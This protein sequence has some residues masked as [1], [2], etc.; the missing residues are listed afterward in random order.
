[1]CSHSL[2]VVTDFS[3]IDMPLFAL[4]A[5]HLPRN[6]VQLSACDVD[7]KALA[8]CRRNHFSHAHY[9]DVTRRPLF[10]PH[11]HLYVAGPPCQ[12]W[13]SFGLRKGAEDKRSNHR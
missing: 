4:R 11:V 7:D 13:S 9:S 10:I 5:L 3:G 12:P 6:L 2:H 8:F 1:M